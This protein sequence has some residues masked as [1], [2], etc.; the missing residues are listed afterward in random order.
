LLEEAWKKKAEEYQQTEE[1]LQNRLGLLKRK[2]NAAKEVCWVW[3][4]F[5]KQCDVYNAGEQATMLNTC[6]QEMAALEYFDYILRKTGDFRLHQL[7]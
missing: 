4:T 1:W 2:V 7:Y 5:R 6:D 3:R